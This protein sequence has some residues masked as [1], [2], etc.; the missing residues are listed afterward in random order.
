MKRLFSIMGLL[1]AFALPN[2]AQTKTDTIKFEV[3]PEDESATLEYEFSEQVRNGI[4]IEWVSANGISS[5]K[6]SPSFSYDDYWSVYTYTQRITDSGTGYI[7][8]TYTQGSTYSAYL[9]GL[10]C[11]DSYDIIVMSGQITSLDLSGCTALTKL[12]CSYNQLTSLDV[13]KNTALTELSC[14][15]NQLT[16]LDVSHNTALT[17]LGCRENQLTSLDV[18]KNTAL[19]YLYCSYNQLTS[20][21][22]SGCTALTDLDCSYNQLTSL[23]VSKNTALT[24]LS[25]EENQLTGLDVSKNTALGGVNCRSNQLTS[26]DVSKNTALEVLYC[27]NNQLT[28]LDVSKNTYVTDLRC[29][30]NHISLSDLYKAYIQNSDWWFNASGQL[31]NIKL[32]PNQFLD[33]SS[34]RMLGTSLSTYTL[35]NNGSAVAADAYKEDNFNFRFYKLG[36]YEL[37]LQNSTLP[38]ADFTWYISVEIPEGYCMVQVKS[39]NPEWGTATVTGEGLYEKGTEVTITATAN[40][41][42]RFVNWTKDGDV[43]S[44]EATYKFIV[45]EDLELTANFEKVPDDVATE[46][47]E[48]DNFYVYAQDRNIVLSKTRGAVQVF[49]AVGQCVYSGNATIIP[50]RQSGVYVVRVGTN[51]YKV[52]VR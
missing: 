35:T 38:G 18:S 48:S 14:G 47:H 15:S 27:E 17:N 4:E 39:N 41:G 43:F 49:N 20:L 1:L 45:T 10:Y 33:L 7:Y 5:G 36:D 37:K 25:C 26:L 22:V 3:T 12:D 11:Y 31:D 8:Y 19:T 16:S 51:A 34:E 24:G 29:N 32:Q 13:S 46:N 50:V 23:D 9:S 6:F 21:D 44:T 52:I 40:E 42:Y 30:N 28:G 2:H